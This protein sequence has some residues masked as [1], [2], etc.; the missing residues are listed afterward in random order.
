MYDLVEMRLIF[1]T[2]DQCNVT[3]FQPLNRGFRLLWLFD[4]EYIMSRSHGAEMNLQSFSRT[5]R[6][7]ISKKDYC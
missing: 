3:E 4:L 1:S 5:E 7:F 2:L 6:S